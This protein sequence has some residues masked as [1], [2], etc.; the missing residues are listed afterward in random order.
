MASLPDGLRKNVYEGDSIT[1]KRNYTEEWKKLPWKK[2]YQTLFRLQH[3]LY[4]ASKENNQKKCLK[5]Q[6][7][8]LGSACSRFIAIRQVTFNLSLRISPI[9]VDKPSLT[10]QQKIELETKLKHLNNWKHQ[11]F[12]R[13]FISKA[14]GN[15][16]AL[17][18]PTL[19]DRIM[20][21]HI[22]HALEPVYEAQVSQGSWK[23][24]QKKNSQDIQKIIALNL[25][26]DAKGWT[27]SILKL[28][29]EKGFD[30]IQHELFLSFILLPQSA[31]NIIKQALK[32]GMLEESK[33]LLTIVKIFLFYYA[34][35]RSMG[36]KT[37]ATIKINLICNGGFGPQAMCYLF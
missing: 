29:I 22:K 26:S 32:K 16:L 37:C 12:Q 33:I 3:K 2:F 1:D 23:F 7:L 24:R 13:V 4:E 11:H 19:E 6:S 35:Q 20:Q 30:T 18:I 36:L 34:T 14:N 27:K 5:F 25:D 21:R 15:K 28:N 17:K 31:K 8:I 10:C 9:G